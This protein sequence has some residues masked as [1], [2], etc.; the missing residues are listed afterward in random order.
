MTRIAVITDIHAN[1]PALEWRMK[2]GARYTDLR[3][4]WA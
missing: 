1:L 4:N 2:S 3:L